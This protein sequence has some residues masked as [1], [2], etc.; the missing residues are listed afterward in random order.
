[1]LVSI[2]IKE[3]VGG[4]CLA[5]II[6]VVIIVIYINNFIIF[7]RLPSLIIL[8]QFSFTY[9]FFWGGS[10]IWWPLVSYGLRESLLN[11]VTRLLQVRCVL[12][13]LL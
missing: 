4:P 5:P 1:M 2:D 3:V 9:D 7:S 12:Y 11:V 10:L 13:L 6:V 8:T